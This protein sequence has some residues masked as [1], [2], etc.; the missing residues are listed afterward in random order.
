MKNLF[1]CLALAL[2]CGCGQ[3]VS[4]PTSTSQIRTWTVPNDNSGFIAEYDFRYTADSS[5][6]W[7]SWTQVFDEPIPGTI[8]TTQNFTMTLPNGIW[9]VAMK[10]RDANHNWSGI[11]NI[12]HVEIDTEPPEIVL[13]L[14]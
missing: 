13:D 1:I 9:F 3:T 14:K 5:L 8:G 10:S 11:S 2:L 7:D 12:T 6:S 4:D